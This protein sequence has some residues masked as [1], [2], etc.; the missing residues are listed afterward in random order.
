MPPPRRPRTE[1]RPSS[2]LPTGLPADYARVLA[3]LRDRIAHER[4]RVILSANSSMVMLYW[5]I[6]RLIL[7]RQAHAGWGAKV[8]DRLAR[9]LSQAFPDM[10]G[11]SP[12]NLKYMKML[13]AAWPRPPIGQQLVAQLPWGQIVCLLQRVKDQGIREWYIRRSIE[14]GWSRSILALQIDNRAHERQGQALSNFPATLPPTDSDMAAQV[15]KDPYLFDFLGTADPRRER[16]VEQ[17]LIDHIQRF[18]LELGRGSRS[19]AA[20]FASRWATRSSISICSSIT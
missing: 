15:F 11:L 13:S 10:R 9:D 14:H 18:L 3:D 8:I 4:L 7:E 2:P 16:E 1:I 19:L 12:R 17:A 20:R 5:D 6:G